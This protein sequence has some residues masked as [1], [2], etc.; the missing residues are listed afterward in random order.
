MLTISTEVMPG[1]SLG[2]DVSF[3]RVDTLTVA[4]G[5]RI[6]SDDPLGN[7]VVFV[8]LSG[9]SVAPVL[10]LAAD[11]LDFGCILS[12]SQ[13]SVMVSNDGTDTLNVS[14]ITFPT[15]FTG[16]MADSVLAPGEGADLMV[17]F[18]PEENGYWTG[19]VLLTSDSYQQPE[20]SVALSAWS[21]VAMDT[22]HN[23][24]SVDHNASVSWPCIISNSGNGTLTLDTIY[25]SSSWYSVS[26]SSTTV[27]SGDSVT[28]LVHFAP[29][30][31]PGVLLDTLVITGDGQDN[32]AFYIPLTGESVWPVLELSN[33][34]LSF[35][36]V[37]VGMV[38]TMQLTLS[39]TGSDTLFVDSIYVSDSLSGFSVS[40][41]EM[42]TYRSLICLLYTSDAADE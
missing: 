17:S 35:G 3:M 15:G 32:P 29:G 39:N 37:R 16:S 10:A 4:D 30:L 28:V 40:L 7:D 2:L 38:E 31:T 5:L 36:D 24:G 12:E 41:G 9:R 1:E 42:N 20:H 34:A 13:L 25:T 11:T 21:M 23:F 22:V 27:A 26:D 6:T 33:E 18:V 19:D 8:G 14:A